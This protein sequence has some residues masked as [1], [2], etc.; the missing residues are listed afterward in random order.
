MSIS[1]EIDTAESA[2]PPGP[3]E[4]KIR[5]VSLVANDL[6]WDNRYHVALDNCTDVSIFANRN[7]L[8]NLRT[9]DETWRIGGHKAGSEICFDKQGKFMGLDVLYSS[10]ASANVLCERD[11]E[12]NY[13]AHYIPN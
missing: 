11:V 7:L 8:E 5:F 10:N 6:E 1:Q 13:T 2:R 12:E 9:A 4:N 3:K